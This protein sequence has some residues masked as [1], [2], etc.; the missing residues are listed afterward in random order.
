[1]KLLKDIGTSLLKGVVFAIL[2]AV[3]GGVFSLI[4]SWPMLKGAYIF[5]LIGG[6]ITMV[7]SIALLIGTPKMRMDMVREGD[8]RKNP[9]RGGEGIAP[10]FMGI[11]M[12]IIGFWLEAMMH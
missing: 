4:K 7:I 1:M 8:Q 11:T 9:Q 12:M 6:S 3:I 2:F 10:A 5:V